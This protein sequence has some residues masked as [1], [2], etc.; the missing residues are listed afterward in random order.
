MIIEAIAFS[1][2]GMQLGNRI[3]ESLK[4]TDKDMRLSLARCPEGGLAAWTDS[5]WEKAD[6][7][8]YIGAIGIAV[9]AI[10]P[11]VKK[12]SRDPAVIVIDELGRFCI[13]LLSGHLGGAN[14]LAL[15]LSEAS[16]AAPVITTATDINGL[17]AADDW[18]R[19]Q[20]LAVPYTERIKPVSSR[21]LAGEK[22]RM[23]SLYPIEGNIPSC[24]EMSEGECDILVSH[25]AE[26]SSALLLVPRIVTLGVGCHKNIE[27]EAL[28]KAFEE[29]LQKSGCLKDAVFQAASIDL[30][31]N[32]PALIEFC[33]RHGLPFRTYSAQELL[34]VPGEFSG[35]EFV[36]KITGVDNVCERAAVLAS[37]GRLIHKK[38]AGGGV[39]M[40]L[41][42][43]EPHLSWK[44]AANG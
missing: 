30:K 33:E 2:R 9:R 7:L 39:T 25:L 24:L 17:F 3:E 14:K 15:R 43:S 13:S 38:E 12:K 6:A 29:M 21:I 1:Q 4:E 42:V 35:S 27:L 18:A 41:A 31:K 23:R 20:G 19:E 44:G 16:G 40:A 11:H 28:E 8:L 5:A 32:E 37:G 26:D 10:A 22:L 34:A 36:K